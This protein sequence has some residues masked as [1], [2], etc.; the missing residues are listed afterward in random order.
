MLKILKQHLEFT[1]NSVVRRVDGSYANHLICSTDDSTAVLVLPASVP[2]GVL[3][4]VTLEYQL[5]DRCPACRGVSEE[6]DLF[7]HRQPTKACIRKGS[8]ESQDWQFEVLDE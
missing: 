5:H 2:F 7:C 4:D 8:Q 3:V 6:H 1:V